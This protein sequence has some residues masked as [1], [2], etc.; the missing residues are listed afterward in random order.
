VTLFDPIF[1]ALDAR[2]VRYVVVGG[3]A[4][5]LHGHVRMTADLDLVVDLE[6]ANVRAAVEALIGIGLAP[7][8]PVDAMDFADPIVRESWVRDKAMTVFSLIDPKDAFRHVDL[9]ADPPVRFAELWERAEVI[10]LPTV[11]VRVASVDDLIAMKRLAARAQDLA[12]IEALEEIRNV[13]E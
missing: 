11:E 12:D 6:P 3:V 9:F 10:R 13:D 8:I 7:T 4:V 1:E 5:V 2:S